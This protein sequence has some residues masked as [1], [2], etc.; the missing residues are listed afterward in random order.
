M[1]T[2]ADAFDDAV[3]RDGDHEA[4]V[5]G[6]RRITF[7]QWLA[8]ADS[9]A[10]ELMDRGVRPG[11]V[12]AIML[13]PSIDFAICYAA[14]ARCGA[15]AT[16]L[17]LRLGPRET[18]AIFAACEPALVIHD[19]T[20]AVVPPTDAAL[21]ERTELE[22]IC[23]RDGL[24]DRRP[25]GKATDPAVIIWTSGTTGTPKGAW[26]DHDNLEAAVA[27]AG[28]MAA[29]HDRRLVATP[30]AHA[31]YLAKLWE[32]LQT[33]TTIV[34]SP[35]PWRAE[36]TARLVVE[37]RITM[38]G[39]VPTQWAKLTELPQLRPE[40]LPHLRVGICATAPASP[41]LI[42]RVR[43]QIGCPLIVRYAMTEAPSITGTDPD[44]PPEVQSQTVGRP[45]AGVEIRIVDDCI[46]VRGS[47][48]MRGYW[49][50]TQA[51][52]DVLDAEGWLT[53]GDLGR[54][55]PEGNLVLI[56][57]A[58]DM[59][60]RGGYNVHPLEVENLLATHPAVDRAAV[61]GVPADVIGEIGV[62]FVVPADPAH[63]PTLAE[64]R[65]FVASHL[66][67]YKCPDQV[68]IV[69]ALPLTA[70]LKI[71]KPTL[72]ERATHLRGRATK[73]SR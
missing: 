66:A 43:E 12:V 40:A 48:V 13:P 62:A 61:V 68:E 70:M 37:E 50:A 11:Q 5:E 4:Y 35:T 71:D 9:M 20:E 38:L 8:L 30:F 16:A 2:V 10:A 36:D 21:I 19:K 73:E 55:T 59:Y 23:S 45:Q 29:R 67:D 26:F 3:R 28:V 15:V 6:D 1:P 39:A 22:A 7:A 69:D 31:G 64:V 17:N 51:T 53:T 18:A 42:E 32:Q 44:D 25:R 46:Q 27:S 54:L 56:G 34:I 65:A 41:E 52:A 24:G 14:I 33:A 47:T 72:R 49:H 63:P 58:S 60:I 57:R